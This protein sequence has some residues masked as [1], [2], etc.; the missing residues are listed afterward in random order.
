MGRDRGDD[1]DTLPHFPFKYTSL[2]M[3][4]LGRDPLF[5]ETLIFMIRYIIP[6]AFPF[7]SPSLGILD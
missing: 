4:F 6:C 7:D 1:K 2:I 3:G 5:F